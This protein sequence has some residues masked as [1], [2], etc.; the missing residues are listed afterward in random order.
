MKITSTVHP[1]GLFADPPTEPGGQ[2]WSHH[3][4]D[5][6]LHYDGRT[7][8]VRYRQGT[9][10]R[11]T[12]A[13]HEVVW[14]VLIGYVPTPPDEP[15]FEDWAADYGYDPDSRRAEAIYN[16]CVAQSRQFDALMGA[17]LA[18]LLEDVANADGDAEAVAPEWC[19]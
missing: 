12:P 4:Y 10:I 16:A 1:L 7:M 2:P 18:L 15:T 6:T 17:D 13:T 3:A 9:G 19:R 5:V 8:S 11:H 14:S